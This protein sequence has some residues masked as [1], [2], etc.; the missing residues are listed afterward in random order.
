MDILVGYI[1]TSGVFASVLCLLIGL[2]W[3][4]VAGQGVLDYQ[5]KDANLAAFGWHAL[6]QTAIGGFAPR[7]FINLGILLLLLTPY[8]RV[9]ASVI[10][11]ALVEKNL[12]YTIFTAIVCGVLTYSLLLR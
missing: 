11:F 7:L 5:I 8:L 12:K 1:L 4:W 3:Q 9:V 6:R 2:G 10:Y